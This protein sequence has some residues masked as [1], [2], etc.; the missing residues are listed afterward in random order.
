MGKPGEDKVV[1]DHI[2]LVA[3]EAGL[4]LCPVNRSAADKASEA[5]AAVIGVAT[6]ILDHDLHGGCRRSKQRGM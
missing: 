1:V 5:P 4:V 3:C 2:G 6:G